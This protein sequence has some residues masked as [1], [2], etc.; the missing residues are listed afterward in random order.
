MARKT[1]LRRKDIVIASALAVLDLAVVLLVQY[2]LIMPVTSSARQERERLA[3][4][5][6][7][8]EDNNRKRRSLL[9]VAEQNRKLAGQLS[10][11][12]QRVAPRK[13]ATVAL[14]ADVLKN[15][16]DNSLKIVSTQPME[17]ADIGQGFLLIPYEINVQGAY[18]DLCRFLCGIES[19][20]SFMEII[21]ADLI[22]Q[23]ESSLKMKIALNL[24]ARTDQDEEP[25]P[26]ASEKASA[27]APPAKNPPR[28]AAPRKN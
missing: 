15:A 27:P 17:P 2:L 4:A 13:A 18:V 14:F 11:F 3:A 5:V 7:E 8:L 26:G 10:A 9:D 22:T 16:S 25:A 20:A 19:N 21:R 23:A 12:D 6:K 1:V 28:S 24:Y